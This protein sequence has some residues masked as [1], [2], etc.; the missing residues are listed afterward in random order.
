MR[1]VLW[2]AIYNEFNSILIWIGGFCSKFEGFKA[3]TCTQTVW[4]FI[5][6]GWSICPEGSTWKCFP[7]LL[8]TSSRLCLVLDL[9][10][11]LLCS[12]LT[13]HSCRHFL[14]LLVELIWIQV[15]ISQSLFFAEL[16][17]SVISWGTL[18]CY[19]L[20]FV[21]DHFYHNVLYIVHHLYWHFGQA[22]E[23]GVAVV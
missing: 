8:F 12:F 23:Y 10:P 19:L 15:W 1:N 14:G 18:W 3:S 13:I 16:A 21:Q 22:C 5:P 9:R 11:S 20:V 6:F 7:F 17:T 4:W 2:I